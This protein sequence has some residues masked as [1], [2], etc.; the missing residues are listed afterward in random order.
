VRCNSK[1]NK[2]AKEKIK[3]ENNNVKR[4][5][6]NNSKERHETTFLCK[7]LRFVGGSYYIIMAPT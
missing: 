3:N 7:L 4:K 6:K 5:R 2:V 1:C